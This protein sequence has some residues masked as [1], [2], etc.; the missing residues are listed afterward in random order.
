M[1]G[2]RR[3]RC[4]MHITQRLR[5]RRCHT[6]RL[7]KRRRPRRLPRV[8][9]RHVYAGL[10]AP[11][12]TSDGRAVDAECGFL[13]Q[14]RR[15][16][17]GRYC[18]GRGFCSCGR[19]FPAKIRRH[20]I[21][22]LRT[23]DAR[24]QLHRRLHILRQPARDVTIEIAGWQRYRGAPCVERHQAAYLPVFDAYGSLQLFSVVSFQQQACSGLTRR[25]I[26]SRC[27]RFAV[28]QALEGAISLRAAEC[29]DA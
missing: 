29:K 19:K 4:R 16:A 6:R 2:R 7:P 25:A 5:M 14:T 24:V 3:F 20:A 11:D 28:T 1:R 26:G 9:Q 10:R 18:R 17:G 8:A 21:K 15:D 27:A 13:R 23:H 22:R 12:V